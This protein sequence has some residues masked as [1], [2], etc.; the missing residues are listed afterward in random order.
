VLVLAAWYPTEEEPVPGI[1]IQDFATHIAVKHLVTVIAFSIAENLPASTLQ[2]KRETFAGLPTI[3]VTQGR[4]VVP[5]F[6]YLSR[7]RGQ[8]RIIRQIFDE[9]N[10]DVIQANN[11]QTVIPALLLGRNRRVPI[12]ALE[13]WSGFYRGM[14]KGVELLKARWA[15]EHADCVMPVSEYMVGQIAAHGIKARYQALP[16]AA[17]TSV[18]HLPP[19]PLPHNDPPEGVMVA[20]LTPI[21][22]HIYLVEAASILK[23]RGIRVVFRLVGGGDDRA[24]LEAKIAQL[25][26]EDYFRFHG[27]LRKPQVGAVM[28]QSDFAFTSS[29]G[30]TFGTAL[31]EGLVAGLPTF[32]T[33]AAAIP[34]L[35]DESRGLLVR[36][37]DPEAFADGMV[38]FLK[39]LPNYNREKI[40]AWAKEKFEAQSVVRQF[41]K[42]C[43]DQ[44]KEWAARSNVW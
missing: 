23:E 30:E 12:I 8:I 32:G 29:L 35:I 9:F 28:Q 14:V 31:S 25:G 43:R 5:K 38:E 4:G 1:F 33:T 34:E 26:V 39:K 19:L 22:G 24:M 40:A 17:D 44:I 7:L 6:R 41:E 27:V 13:Q 16:V 36:P 42:V 10:P 11:Y 3:R 21:K 20:T 15:F 18:F 37:A 2:I